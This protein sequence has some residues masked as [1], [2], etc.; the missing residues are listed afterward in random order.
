M[1][2]LDLKPAVH[3]GGGTVRLV[4]EFD[5]ELSDAVR[6]YAL[7]LMEAPSGR[8]LVYAP[9]ANGGRRT[10]TF[11]SAMATA[12]TQVAL[13]ELERHVTADGTTS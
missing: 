3:P 8:H 6:L 7:R 4:A 2:V 11:S 12:I 5:L 13:N 1:R 9:N 10:A